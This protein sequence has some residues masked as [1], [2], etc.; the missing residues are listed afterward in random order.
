MR[1]I[2]ISIIVLGTA[3]HACFAEVKLLPVPLDVTQSL[4]VS[5]VTS[6]G[7]DPFGLYFQGRR[8]AVSD[9]PGDGIFFRSLDITSDGTQIYGAS[10]D[11]LYAIDPASG[12]VTLL[13][14][15]R[16]DHSARIWF[17]DS[18]AYELPA[19]EAATSMDWLLRATVQAVEP[20]LSE[21]FFDTVDE[22][23]TLALPT[24]QATTL[25]SAEFDVPNNAMFD[26][27]L[28]WYLPFADPPL[29]IPGVE[30]LE[31]DRMPY[32]Q[33][34]IG[35][36][37][38]EPDPI[39]GGDTLPLSGISF[40]PD[41]ML[42]GLSQGD[43][44]V[45]GRSGL[46]ALDVGTNGVRATFLVQP[47]F[48]LDAI[49]FLDDGTLV[50]AGAALFEVD[51][52]TGAMTEIGTTGVNMIADMDVAPN[53]NLRGVTLP[54]AGNSKLIWLPVDGSSPAPV[55]LSPQGPHWGIA[56]R[57]GTRQPTVLVEPRSEPVRGRKNATK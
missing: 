56:T 50:G 34:M 40:S 2:L 28:L 46:Y 3:L 23:G 12:A 18:R 57:R 38:D 11:E 51:L 17:S 36:A 42:V 26:F 41:G 30:L 49:E 52:T 54:E 27:Y 20:G 22:Q 45:H 8:I 35:A 13:G 5:L 33:G 44:D 16:D 4:D 48:P 43:W 9:P 53:G 7:E 1:T 21:V 10:W 47:E 6:G 55:T 15:I 25:F 32:V 24:L 31:G 39:S 29:M 37:F 14:K 19:A